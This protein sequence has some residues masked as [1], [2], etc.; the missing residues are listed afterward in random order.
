MWIYICYIKFPSS[1]HLNVAGSVSWYVM[2]LTTRSQAQFLAAVVLVAMQVK[3]IHPWLQNFGSSKL[4]YSPPLQCFSLSMCLFS[5]L[6]LKFKSFCLWFH[7]V[8]GALMHSTAVRRSSCLLFQTVAYAGNLSTAIS[9]KRLLAM[10]PIYFIASFIDFIIE[11]CEYWKL[12]IRR[13]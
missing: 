4:I 8:Q 1:R 12:W 7:V 10:V 9:R 13:K 11:A 6:N 2:L 3:N 5:T